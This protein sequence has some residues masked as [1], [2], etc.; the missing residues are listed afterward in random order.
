MQ[1]GT[2]WTQDM[3]KVSKAQWKAFTK[4]FKGILHSKQSNFL[5][6][7]WGISKAGKIFVHKFSKKTTTRGHMLSTTSFFLD[8]SWT[9]VKTDFVHDQYF[10][11]EASWTSYRKRIGYK[12][13]WPLPGI[14]IQFCFTIRLVCMEFPRR[15][16]SRYSPAGIFSRL[17]RRSNFPLRRPFSTSRLT[18]FTFVERT[19]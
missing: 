5:S 7:K 13:N 18:N 11:W 2:A 4:G 19:S 1:H 10:F 6:Q 15:K 9:S 14:R 3:R 12:P 8:A 17:K 16:S